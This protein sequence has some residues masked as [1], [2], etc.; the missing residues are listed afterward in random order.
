MHIVCNMYD[1]PQSFETSSLLLETSWLVDMQC[2]GILK[3]HQ[4]NEILV[5]NNIILDI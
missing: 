3:A 2:I 1:K 5:I 4:I